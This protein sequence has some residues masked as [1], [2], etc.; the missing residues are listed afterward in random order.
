[1]AQL[2]SSEE[3][4]H[5]LYLAEG[6]ELRT[7]GFSGYH[8]DPSELMPL[9]RHNKISPYLYLQLKKIQHPIAPLLEEDYLKIRSKNLA[10]LQAG[11]PVLKELRE[12]GVEVIIL[13]GNAIAEEVFGDIGYKPMNDIDILVKQADLDTVYEIFQKHQ[14][15]S[16]GALSG[17][18]RKQEKYSHHWPPFFTKD[19]ACFFGTHWNLAAQG[20]GLDLPLE[21]FWQDKE[22]FTLLGEKFFRLSPPHFLL[23]LCVHLSPVKTGLR[24]VGDIA[25]WI[26]HSRSHLSTD[27]FITLVLQAKA[28]NDVYE[29]LSL[30]AALK[31]DPFVRTVLQELSVVVSDKVKRQS[32]ERCRPSRKI[33]Y[34]RTNYISKIEKT[35]AFFMMTEAPL[36]K[37]LLL[38]KMWKLYLF[39]PV[40]EACRLCHVLPDDDVFAKM[41]AVLKAPLKIS[42]VFAK[43]LGTGV[44]VFVTLRHQ[45][46]L[47]K[48]YVIYFRKKLLSQPVR[49]LK[50][51]A[52]EFGLDM[53]RLREMAALD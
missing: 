22:E 42:Q 32:L 28:Q 30:V 48:A 21:K 4:I 25:K 46:V 24:E 51:V 7:G 6:D 18:F 40:L 8:L 14:L 5:Q 50:S 29:A 47:L 41:F 11:I 31:E 34:M 9:A 38:A 23:H 53:S 10:R 49:N 12:R 52:A 39:V 16:A 37:T 27:S 13:K 43:D 26:Q 44:F 19:L 45:W 3:F 1:M 2:R 20:R 35:F 36:E 17:D 33:L 15:A